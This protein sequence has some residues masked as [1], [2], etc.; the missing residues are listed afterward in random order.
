MSI[1]EN[2][3]DKSKSF[4]EFINHYINYQSECLRQLGDVNYDQLVTKIL[5]CHNNGNKII[6]IGNGGSASNATHISTGLSYITRN[7]DRPLRSL[8]LT[9]DS[10]LITSL[11]NDFS[12]EDIFENQLKIHLSSGDLILALSTSGNSL[13][14]LKAVKYAKTR[15][16][17]IASLTGHDGGELKNLSDFNINI[18]SEHVLHGIAEDAHMV[19][20]HALSYYLEY[21]FKKI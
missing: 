12:F 4:N 2:F 1:I 9:T 6:V 15:G 11:A 8:P 5:E 10:I 19:W 16:H 3:F 17:F 14:I 13:N 7:W 21:Y 20:G 18:K